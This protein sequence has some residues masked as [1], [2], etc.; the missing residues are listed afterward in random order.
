M[1]KYVCTN[2]GSCPAAGKVIELP[3]GA[4]LV[5]PEDGYQLEE[6]ED[7]KGWFALIAQLIARRKA[8]ASVAAIAL[9][10]VGAGAWY[11]STVSNRAPSRASP[12][13]TTPAALQ[14]GSGTTGVAPDEEVLAAQKQ[15]ADKKILGGATTGAVAAQSV[16]IANEYIKAAVPLM[17]AGKWDEAN[18]QL[19]KAT[20]ENP[21]EPLIYYNKAI[22]QLKQGKQKD[23]LAAL[24]MALQKG[25]KD[26]AALEGDSDLKPLRGLSEYTA[27]VAKYKAK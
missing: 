24:D 13:L 4:E 3:P 27:I 23:A 14:S 6:A 22:I 25:F 9:V 21:D 20:A 11:V 5:C 7:S 19:L 2:F 12:V 1:P 15:D 10:A 16:V 17:Q 26:F 18:A 8:V